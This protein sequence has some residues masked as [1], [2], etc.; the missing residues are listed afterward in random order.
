MVE[1]P[2]TVLRREKALAE[3]ETRFWR[4][5]AGV[6]LAVVF[7]CLAIV[8]SSLSLGRAL[9]RELMAYRKNCIQ[10]QTAAQLILV[11]ERVS[12]INQMCLESHKRHID[13][14]EEALPGVFDPIRR[15]M[16]WEVL[17]QHGGNYEWSETMSAAATNKA[18]GGVLSGE[19]P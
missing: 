3:Q 4:R 12:K 15:V 14:L 11:T 5:I 2:I 6:C 8:V 9:A 16:K 19:E 10:P 7:V 17:D 18:V 13:V 1:H